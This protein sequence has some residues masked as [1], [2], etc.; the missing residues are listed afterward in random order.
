MRQDST[1]SSTNCGQSDD[2]GTAQVQRVTDGA[3]SPL[4]N[5][6]G[7]FGTPESWKTLKLGKTCNRVMTAASGNDD[8]RLEVPKITEDGDSE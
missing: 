8:A 3:G 6:S 5:T 4:K 1:S 2:D 7:S